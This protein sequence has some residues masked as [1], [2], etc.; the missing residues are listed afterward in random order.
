M[1]GSIG[2]QELIVGLTN[3]Y[4]RAHELIKW[5]SQTNIVGLTNSRVFAGSRFAVFIFGAIS[6]SLTLFY[7]SIELLDTNVSNEL[8][9]ES[10]FWS[11]GTSILGN[12]IITVTCVISLH[13]RSWHFRYLKAPY[14]SSLRPHTLVA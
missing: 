1:I 6:H 8:G 13:T 3:S 5:G 14:T 9:Q 4:S 10:D 12:L 11:A 2:D 7:I